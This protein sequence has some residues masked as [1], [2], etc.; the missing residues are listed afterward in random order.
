IIGMRERMS[1]LGGSLEAG[2]K[3][4][5][6]WLV[7]AQIPY[8]RNVADAEEPAPKTKEPAPDTSTMIPTAKA[9]Q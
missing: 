3:S 5:G 4:R 2:P 8:P 9:E 7:R 6:G 1:A